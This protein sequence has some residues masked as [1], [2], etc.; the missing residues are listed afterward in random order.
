VSG[1]AS[2]PHDLRI[3]VAAGRLAATF[4]PAEEPAS[5][6]VRPVLVA[7]PGGTYTRRYFDLTVDGHPGYSFARHAAARGFPVLAVDVLGTG[8]STRPDGEVTLEDQAA[9]LAEALADLPDLV[10]TGGPFVAVGHSMGGYVAMAQQAAHASYAALAILGTTNRHVAPLHLP[11]E[12]IAAGVGAS[13]AVRE[14]LVDQIA[15]GMPDAY[16]A[17]ARDDLLSWFHLADVPPAVVEA[18]LASTLTVVPRRC[19]AAS[20]VPGTTADAAAIIEVP[21]FLAYGDVD[22]SPDPHGEPACFPASRDVTLYVL[23]GSA[24]CHNMA[25]TRTLLWDRLL[26]WCA[27]VS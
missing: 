7:I 18:D 20:T 19:A 27:T 5:P 23:A 1:V 11:D 24:H 10:G 17:G 14:A 21:V 3:D 9:A 4:H 12:L 15:A 16:I 2:V 8:D 13:A 6:G 25:S 22:V 26:A